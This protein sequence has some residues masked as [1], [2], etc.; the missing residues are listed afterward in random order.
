[1]IS[2]DGERQVANSQEDIEMI[3]ALTRN[4]VSFSPLMLSKRKNIFIENQLRGEGKNH[5]DF[6]LKFFPKDSKPNIVPIGTSGNVQDSETFIGVLGEI[7]KVANISSIGIQD[8]DIWF[9]VFL[10]QYMKSE[11]SLSGFLQVLRRQKSIYIKS[12]LG[13]NSYYFNFWE[14]ENLYLMPEV[15]E[16]WTDKKSTSLTHATFKAFLN[17]KHKEISNQYFNTF[18]KGILKIRPS[19]KVAVA[20]VRA[21]VNKKFSELDR[22]LK[23]DQR[24][25]SRMKELVDSILKNDLLQW[26]PGKEIKAAL[27]KVGYEFNDR[28]FKF[29]KSALSVSVRKIQ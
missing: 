25:E 11:L 15:L 23:E 16:C 21:Q 28:E 27:E 9:K 12:G 5:R 26:V 10:T 8:G 19:E 24:L 1:V 17:Q 6:F 13:A 7:L 4:G 18:Y 20:K 14:I 22:I 3:N 29:E 2:F